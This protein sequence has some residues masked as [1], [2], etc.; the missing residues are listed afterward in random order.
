MSK[1]F[2]ALENSA[3][4]VRAGSFKISA[5]LFVIAGLAVMPVSADEP[6]HPAAKGQQ[7]KAQP[8]KAAQ[9]KPAA[10]KTA[11]VG[12]AKQTVAKPEAAGQAKTVNAAAKPTAVKKEG[13]FA[14]PPVGAKSQEAL[15]KKFE[16]AYKNK[17]GSAYIALIKTPFRQRVQMELQFQREC[18]SPVNNFKLVSVEHE[19]YRVKM[20][21][22]NI[23][24]PRMVDG[25]QE[26]YDL[27]VVGFINYDVHTNVQA[28]PD[29]IGMAIGEDKA[30]QT[31]YIVTRHPVMPAKP[32]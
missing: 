4:S 8:A 20:P 21:S 14:D 13:S 19:I 11:P 26:D 15:L 10:A 1:L 24:K 32:H 12:Q 31:F 9:A 6:A 29:V 3:S 23:G 17:D 25:K 5:A 27:P 16:E 28:P 7:T 18:R 2:K 22:A 30:K